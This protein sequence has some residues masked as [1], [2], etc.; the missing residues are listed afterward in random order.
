MLELFGGLFVLV[1]CELLLLEVPLCEPLLSD[2]P[3]WEL[4]LDEPSFPCI[5]PELPEE[6]HVWRF[7]S[8]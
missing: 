2:V 1:S 5:S 4:L 6:P 7:E 3:P 8:L